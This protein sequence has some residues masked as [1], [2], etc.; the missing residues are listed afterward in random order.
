MDSLKYVYFMYFI[1]KQHKM[2][3][4]YPMNNRNSVF[5]ACQ[6]ITAACLTSICDGNVPSLPREKLQKSQKKKIYMP[7][8]TEKAIC[9]LH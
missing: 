4:T 2:C 7:A 6:L 9:D 5:F 8:L 3:S 1:I